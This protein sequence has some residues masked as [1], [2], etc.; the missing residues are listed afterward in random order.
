MSE[1]RKRRKAA[2]LTLVALA[3]K[4]GV[5]FSTVQAIETG[6]AKSSNI[7]YKKAIAKA[8][9]VSEAEFYALWPEELKKLPGRVQKLIEQADEVRR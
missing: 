3:R 4:S 6:R 1:M 2:G 8:L 7:K 5:G 9:G